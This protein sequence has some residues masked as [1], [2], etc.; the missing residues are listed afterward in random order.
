MYDQPA[1]RTTEKPSHVHC[2]FLT[3][4]D[5]YFE[6]FSGLLRH[7]NIRMHLAATLEQADFLLT[8][9]DATVLLCDTAFL[10]GTWDKAAGMLADVHPNVALVVMMDEL[11]K[12][13]RGPALD[14]GVCHLVSKPLRMSELR[15]AIQLAHTE[16]QEGAPRRFGAVLES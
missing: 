8:V 5:Y 2:V 13:L 12:S 9:T 11:D 16:A 15:Q 3:C 1:T 14:H 6:V 10:D 7:A 4:F